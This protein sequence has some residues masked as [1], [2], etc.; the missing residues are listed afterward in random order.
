MRE[1]KFNFYNTHTKQ[2]TR[3]EESNAG[4]NMCSFF[5]HEHLRFL[6]YTG[7]KD[8][9]GVEIYEGDIIQADSSSPIGNEVTAQVYFKEA[10]FALLT[11]RGSDTSIGY[12]VMICPFAE[13][14]GNIYQHKHLLE[15]Q[16][17]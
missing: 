4:M 11:T 1:I 9:N 3:W 16:H 2:Y 6:Q 17:D 14:I 5:T 13:V 12:L 7:L 15:V 10:G 8:K